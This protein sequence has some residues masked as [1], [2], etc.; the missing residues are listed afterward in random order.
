MEKAWPL[1]MERVPRAKEICKLLEK[2][3]LIPIE[4]G[5]LIET[6]LPARWGKNVTVY[7][8]LKY[9]LTK[10]PASSQEPSRESTADCSDQQSMVASADGG[11]WDSVD[12][13]VEMM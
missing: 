5:R 11:S 6:D 4:R 2:R 13:D 12:Q 3:I 1:I 7:M 8:H 9:F 10:R